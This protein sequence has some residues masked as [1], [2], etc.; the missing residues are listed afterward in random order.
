MERLDGE[1]AADNSPSVKREIIYLGS[2]TVGQYPLV[3]VGCVENL[4][5]GR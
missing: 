4:V 2:R 3:R 5:D 1:P